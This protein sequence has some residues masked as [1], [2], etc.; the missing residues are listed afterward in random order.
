MFLV[1]HP[2]IS[3]ICNNK[4]L[5]NHGPKLRLP[6]SVGNLINVR[7]KQVRSSSHAYQDKHHLS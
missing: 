3:Y 2:H 6:E 4:W 5:D 1:A 7:V